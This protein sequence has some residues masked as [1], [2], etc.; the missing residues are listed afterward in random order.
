[1]KKLTTLQTSY[2]SLSST[3]K[4]LSLNLE[5]SNNQ[6][7]DLQ[8][9]LRQKEK[10]KEEWKIKEMEYIGTIQEEKKRVSVLKTCR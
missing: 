7:E 3:N 4:Q 10:E 5:K 6:I 1:M 2:R 8:N 9:K